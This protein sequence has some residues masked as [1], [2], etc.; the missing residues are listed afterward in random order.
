MIYGNAVT[1][2]IKMVEND[3][4]EICL[5]FLFLFFIIVS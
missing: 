3:Q 5:L 1:L 2:W 4:I